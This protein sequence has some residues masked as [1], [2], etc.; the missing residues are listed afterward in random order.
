MIE[1]PIEP[2][3]KAA[4]KLIRQISKIDEISC[5][6]IYY[7][8]QN[9]ANYE[10]KFNNLIKILKESLIN[11]NFDYSALQDFAQQL[12]ALFKLEEHYFGD[13][14]FE[15]CFENLYQNLFEI[16]LITKRNE[17]RQICLFIA[18]SLKEKFKKVKKA[19]NN[20]FIIYIINNLQLLSNH[21]FNLDFKKAI[22][23]D[24]RNK[25]LDMFSLFLEVFIRTLIDHANNENNLVKPFIY[26]IISLLNL[27]KNVNILSMLALI[28]SK[29]NF[30]NFEN[31]VEETSEILNSILNLSYSL[32]LERY[33]IKK[34]I[35]ENENLIQDIIL[36]AKII[37]QNFTERIRYSEILVNTLFKKCLL[38]RLVLYSADK[39][40]LSKDFFQMT[41]CFNDY[42]ISFKSSTF[43]ICEIENLHNAFS[44]II[45]PEILDFIQPYFMNYYEQPALYYLEFL[46]RIALEIYENADFERIF[47]NSFI[48]LI[49]NLKKKNQFILNN[50]VTINYYI[51]AAFNNCI[52]CRKN[53]NDVLV[54]LIINLWFEIYAFSQNDKIKSMF[55]TTVFLSATN[56]SKLLSKNISSLLKYFTNENDYEYSYIIEQIFPYIDLIVFQS[57]DSRIFNK[58]IEDDLFLKNNITLLKII[59]EYIPNFFIFKENNEEIRIISLL[60]KIY[61]SNDS[62]L[63]YS[64]N[65]LFNIFIE[66]LE[67]LKIIKPNELYDLYFNRK[68]FYRLI[69]IDEKNHFEFDLMNKIEGLQLVNLIHSVCNLYY[70][71]FINIFEKEK[72]KTLITEL[73]EIYKIIKNK[74]CVYIFYIL[75]KIATL[76]NQIYLLQEHYRL[77]K[78]IEKYEKIVEIK[79]QVILICEIIKDIK[80][81][82]KSNLN[83]IQNQ[84]TASTDTNLLKNLENDNLENCFQKKIILLKDIEKNNENCHKYNLKETTDFKIINIPLWSEELCYEIEIKDEWVLISKRLG[85]SESKIEEWRHNTNPARSMLKEWFAINKKSEAISDILILFNELNMLDYVNLIQRYLTKIEILNSENFYD[86][87]IDK[88]QIFLIFERESLEKAKILKKYLKKFNLDVWYDDGKI[89]GEATRN[90]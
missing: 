86:E 83:S 12:T 88:S 84:F 61:N 1:H 60:G 52:L 3:N 53:K 30:F 56:Q 70:F 13:N 58:L 19:R 59:A 25:Y 32:T 34:D 9:E 90:R 49:K 17:A 27:P 48:Y 67:I 35:E 28:L 5:E 18:N 37:N 31:Y 16:F 66:K 21:Y 33:H 81:S 36:K 57:Y 20:H 10:Y 11:V 69:F 54:E 38:Q 43:E 82:R 6:S 8:L 24:E 7:N 64:L 44:V 22:I 87:E 2:Y 89:D 51:L 47:S 42:L 65:N 55:N 79:E 76:N 46:K 68:K 72:R 45:S 78:L 85:F 14:L 40:M 4:T 75:K 71:L 77:F 74:D 41:R 73:F 39:R 23:E 50:E 62:F 29:E 26:L 63:I 80:P 15:K